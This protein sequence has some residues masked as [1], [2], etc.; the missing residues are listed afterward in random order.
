MPRDHPGHAGSDRSL[1]D[2]AGDDAVAFAWLF[3]ERGPPS[4][5]S[6]G[7]EIDLLFCHDPRTL[8]Q[9]DVKRYRTD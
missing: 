7:G 6:P 5:A 9:G 1:Y 4:N 3:A 8:E 2:R